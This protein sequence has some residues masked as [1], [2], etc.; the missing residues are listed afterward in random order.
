MAALVSVVTAIPGWSHAGAGTAP[1]QVITVEAATSR[2]QTAVLRTWRETST[3]RYVQVFAAVVAF[4]GVN[5]VG[6]T[7]EGLGRTPVGV[8]SL[9]EAFGN[10]PNNGTRLPYIQVGANDW[11]DENPASA[12]YNRLVRSVVSPGGN[13][14]NL[15]DAGVAYAHAVI[16]NYNVSPVVKGAGSGFFL[17]V[18]FGAP[19]EGCVA[20]PESDLDRVMRWL[21]PTLH[22]VISVGVGRAALSLVEP[23]S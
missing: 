23:A 2:S 6:P 13:S 10:R 8:Y 14:E 16:I 15:Y 18:S 20:I 1:G 22:P 21:I 9:T 7:S 5:G 19:T 11:W 4:V 12:R 3:G 17:H